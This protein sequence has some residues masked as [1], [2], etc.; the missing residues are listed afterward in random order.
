MKFPLLEETSGGFFYFG[1]FSFE[2]ERNFYDLWFKMY[3]TK[4]VEKSLVSVRF[5]A[6]N[7]PFS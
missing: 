6:F 7:S 4:K 5:S 1:S 2:T 3:R